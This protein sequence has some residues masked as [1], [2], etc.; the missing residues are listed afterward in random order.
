VIVL[1]KKL[2]CLILIGLASLAAASLCSV[3]RLPMSQAVLL[4]LGTWVVLI[5]LF[6]VGT[7]FQGNSNSFQETPR[8][9]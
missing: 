7:L 3:L 6:E 9:K 4:F 5:T 2:F 1:S 8:H